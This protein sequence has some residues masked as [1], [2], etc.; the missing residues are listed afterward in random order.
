[1]PSFFTR[2]ARVAPVG[3]LANNLASLRNKLGKN[4]N[5]NEESRKYQRN[6]NGKL[7][8]KTL[9]QYNINTKFI[10]KQLKYYGISSNNGPTKY[11]REKANKEK[12]E[13]GQKD[14]CPGCRV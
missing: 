8:T 1:M 6:E 12:A 11:F 14:Q 13:A 9:N 10:N 7:T 2:K 3:N 4:K 5:K